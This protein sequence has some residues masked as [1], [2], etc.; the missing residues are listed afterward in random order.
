MPL[1][2]H[3]P[4]T[5]N[6]LD[7]LGRYRESF[8][9]K[10]AEVPACEVPEEDLLMQVFGITSEMKM[11]ERQY[12]GRELG[13]C[14]ERLVH[15]HA[16]CHPAYEPPFRDDGDAPCDFI[17]GGCAVDTKYR[18]GSGDSGTQKK[19]RDYAG[20]LQAAGFTPVMLVLREDNLPGA[21]ESL[22]RAGWDVRRGEA[23]FEWI[24]TNLNVD[25][26]AELRAQR[27]A[28]RIR[29]VEHG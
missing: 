2:S 9:A 15:A 21:L 6:T 22:A 14:W 17:V 7:L 25:V 11:A 27:G 26:Q 20:R 29:G 12:W 10:L 5:P 8:C 4:V 18:F 24:R 23:A 13:M 28:F 1:A 3:P 19:L 16:R